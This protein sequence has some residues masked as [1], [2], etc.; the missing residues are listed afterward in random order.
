MYIHLRCMMVK[1]KG[2]FDHFFRMPSIA[3]SLSLWSLQSGSRPLARRATLLACFLFYCLGSLT[4]AVSPVPVNSLPTASKSPSK[5]TKDIPSPP[6]AKCVRPFSLHAVMGPEGGWSGVDG[7]LNGALTT[8]VSMRRTRACRGEG[9]K[10]GS[11]DASHF[12]GSCAHPLQ[13]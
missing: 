7:G 12:I 3:L 6:G 5:S 13:E 2:V 1:K 4:C 8:L 11:R 9:C 10:Q